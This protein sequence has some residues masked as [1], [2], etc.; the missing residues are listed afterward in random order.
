MEWK[1]EELKKWEGREDEVQ[2]ERE[3]KDQDGA[4]E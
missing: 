2:K 4:L 1:D 3:W